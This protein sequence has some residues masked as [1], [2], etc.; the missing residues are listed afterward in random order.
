MIKKILEC[1]QGF[2]DIKC[3]VGVGG[4][5]RVA[6]D[7]IVTIYPTIKGVNFDQPNLIQ[8]KHIAN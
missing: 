6:L 7:M 2:A 4:G 5:L 8:T 3:L 1:Y